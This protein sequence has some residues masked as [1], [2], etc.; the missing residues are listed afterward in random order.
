MKKHKDKEWMVYHIK[1]LGRLLQKIKLI[2]VFI[3]FFVLNLSASNAFSQDAKLNIKV[4]Q[5]TLKALFKQIEA[6][7]G[8]SFM[9]NNDLVNDNQRVDVNVSNASLEDVLKEP[10]NKYNLTFK[11]VDHQIVIYPKTQQPG[12]SKSDPKR[13]ITV[14]GVVKDLTGS[15][16]PG[17][18]VTVLGTTR[19]VLADNDGSYSIE[20]NSQD[21]LVF[22]FLGME[23]QTIPVGSN[24]VINVT[25]QDKANELKD[26]TVVAFGKQKKASV[27]GSITTIQ[28]SELKV[29]SS[30]LTTALA[31]RMA[32]LISYQ[33]SGEPG[34]D[35]ADFFVRGIT[36]FGTNTSPLILIDGVEMTSE[37]LSN[38]QTDDIS[39]FSILKDATA[40]ALYGARAANGVLLI[41]TKEGKVGKAKLSVRLENSISQPTSNVE[42]AD[43][44]T[45]MKLYNEAVLTRDP[46]GMTLYSEDKINNTVVGSNSLIY[47]ANDWY[48]LLFKDNTTT[49]RVNLNL[50]GGGDVARYYVAGSYS[51]D[52]GMLKVDKRNNFNS[53]IDLRKYRLRSNVNINLTKSTELIVRMSGNFDDYSGPLEGGTAMYNEVMHSNPVLFPA[54]WPVD[55][56]HQYVTHTMFGNYDYG[57]YTNPYA[58]MVKGYKDYSKSVMM[59]QVEMKQDLKAITEGLSVRAMINTTRNSYFDVSRAYN[60]YWY[61]LAGYDQYTGDYSLGLLNASDVLN[62]SG[63]VLVAAG[64]DYLDYSEGEKTVSSKNYMEV[65]MNYSR[66]FN[67]KHNVSGLL[68]FMGSEELKGNAGDLQ[69]SLPFRNIGLSGRATY[70]YSNRYF[71]EFN[72]G[73]N[74]SE[75]FSKSHRFG[76]F[77]SGGL[78][79]QVSNEDFWLPFKPVVTNL[80][81]RASYGLVGNDQIGSDDDRFYYMSVVDMDDE[82]IVAHFG[83]DNEYKLNG[84]TVS[85]YANP[86][87]TWEVAKKKNIALE[88]G[89]WRDFNIIAEYYQEYRSNILM[90]R[91]I[92]NTMGLASSVRANTGAASGSGVDI[93]LNYQKAWKNQMWL[94][95]MGNFT[96]STSK[97]EVYEEP[98][99]LEPW[100]YHVGYSLKQ[101]YGY[102][103]EKLFTDEDEVANSPIQFG[104]Y[105]AGDIKYTDVNND[106]KITEADMVP[107]G[108]PTTPEIVYG[109][110]FSF[111]YKNWDFSTFFQGLTNE[112]F[113]IDVSSGSKSTSPFQNQTQLL[114]AYSD[115]YWSEDNPDSYAVWPR[116]STTV[117]TNNSQTSTWFMRD[118]SFLRLKS[119]EV[120][121][122]LPKKVQKICNTSTFRFY[123]SGT[124]LLI[125]SKFKIWDA[126]M[127]GKGLGY[128]IQKV[129]NLGLNVAF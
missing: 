32:G 74:G 67:E 24:S 49:Q 73:Y 2:L 6:Q 120:G 118:G 65:A 50:S 69:S 93:S 41:T 7:S 56:D 125:F 58:D 112:S 26:V 46:L 54:Y 29:P 37:D 21:K 55:A 23:S 105:G 127:G 47:P 83:T 128:P 109:F 8:Y 40:T 35:N 3:F 20:V 86:D 115:S 16:I 85:R 64:T 121:Y 11:I 92:P 98:Q 57:Q 97:Y 110:G 34:Q 4:R 106:G 119:L 111:G 124:N 77:P 104:D 68:V 42:L 75:R 103:A 13:R 22:T 59:A 18:T 1:E 78:A 101:T 94:S 82:D 116:L 61:T 72:F 33:R 89:L 71:T 100:R 129:F 117:N 122:T 81:L 95:I 107:I 60:P 66:A 91:Y 15:T 36:T 48:K 38:L 53:N 63:K 80:K 52:N 88:L 114:K 25:L 76:F 87:I 123:L 45:Y 17:T 96:Y 30:N 62:A 43:P 90:T 99:Y 19:G 70:A 102:L 126:E 27:V 9:Y 44:V 113:W 12:P 28:P 84:V 10:L 51:K 5:I 108:N 79:W 31:G 14:R 39:S